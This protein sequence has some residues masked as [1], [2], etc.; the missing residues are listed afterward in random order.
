MKEFPGLKVFVVLLFPLLVGAC[1]VDRPPT[2]G[3]PDDTPLSITASI[4]EN[5]T[6]MASPQTIRLDFSHY[7]SREALAKSIY[8]SPSV[9]D[10]EVSAHGREARIRIYSP[11]KQNRTYTLTLRNDLKSLYGDHRL[12]KSW[13]LSFS[14]GPVIDN[15]SIE[16]QVWTPR[17]SP[18]ANVT[19]MAFSPANGTSLPG[20]QSPHYITQTGPSGA[21][22][23]EH[24]APGNYRIEAITDKN[25]NLR[26]DPA[27]ESF[28]VATAKAVDASGATAIQPVNLR[29][30][31]DNQNSPALRSCRAIN[32]R[33]IELTFNRPIPS[34]NLKLSSFAIENTATGK[35]LPVLAGFSLSRA[36]EAI[37]WRLLTGGMDKNVWYR[38]RFS[39][40]K[41]P[42]ELTFY[43]NDRK[44]RYPALSLALIPA[45]GSENVIAETIRPGSTPAA[46]LH[47]NLPVVASSFTH[48]AVK[49]EL[50][51]PD[52]GPR[53]VPFTIE[54]IDSRTYTI[55]PSGAFLPG[56]SYTLQVELSKVES[57]TDDSATASKLVASSFTIAGKELYGEINGGG[58]VM[59]GARRIVIEARAQG[60]AFTKRLEATPSATTGKFSFSFTGL[61]AGRYVLSAFT[62]SGLS[63]SWN[64]GSV[65]PFTPA[66]AFTAKTVEVRSGWSTDDIW[67]EIKSSQQTKK[68]ETN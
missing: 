32:N 36:T 34:E 28:A 4:P 14:T 20:K 57:I 15:G 8:F 66:D 31:E 63:T 13:G 61:P 2:G 59:G 38:L 24:L 46:E 48:G 50:I 6:V 62:P 43:A 19:V 65:E 54:T 29:L 26:Y 25:S 47:F 12:N 5:G 10:F 39:D 55:Q 22:H 51:E 16:G 30:S 7:V 21:F 27:S 53:A 33:E 23:F 45:N 56:R 64:A 49:L 9:D 11:L 3:S 52:D 44:D 67:L 35:P 41:A 42:S 58:K 40:G 17:M 60:S 1:A 68:Q 18:A 37:G